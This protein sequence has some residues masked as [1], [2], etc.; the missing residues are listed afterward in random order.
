MFDRGAARIAA[1]LVAM[2]LA[3]AAAGAQASAESVG[4]G[5][6]TA[7]Y[8]SLEAVKIAPGK[9]AVVVD[10]DRNELH[11]R[12]G[13]TTLWSAPIGTGTGLKLQ[14]EGREWEF[15]TPRGVFQVQYKAQNP[16]WILPDWY[17]IENDLPIP[18]ADDPKRR[19]PGGL[20]AAAVYLGDEI[21]IHGT[22]KPE[23]L[24]QRVSHGC[25]RMANDDALRLFHNVQIGT[26]VII[27]GNPEPVRARAQTSRARVSRTASARS[28]TPPATRRKPWKSLDTSALLRQLDDLLWDAASEAGAPKWPQ[29][30]SELMARG[31]E[32]DADAL[33][34]VLDRLGRA[35]VTE[36]E[37]ATFLADAYSRGALRTLAALSDLNRLARARAAR[38][39]VEA[40]MDLYPGQLDDMQAPW[41]TRRV[42][43]EAVGANERRGWEA[44]HA[45]EQEYR[46]TLDQ[47]RA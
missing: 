28:S 13:R 17:F 12:R 23:L 21:A 31:L 34:G 35:S 46:S 25:I 38:A 40:T 30:A 4:M 10:L 19:Q 44:L 27:V 14:A 45:A 41:P 24:G 36:R 15:S 7:A 32:G 39:I 3:P 11:F 42:P 1:F 8:T 26:Q 2:L 33:T 9:Y 20:G 47:R 43:R 6:G 29:G 5:G 18:P 22:D 37:Y 16:D